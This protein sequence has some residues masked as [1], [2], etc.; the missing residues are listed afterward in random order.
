MFADL[1]KMYQPY[2]E[3]TSTN[4]MALKKQVGRYYKGLQK[5]L[6]PMSDAEQQAFDQ[7]FI[8]YKKQKDAMVK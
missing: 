8:T 4:K 7:A 1:D 3:G 2:V 5:A 6:S